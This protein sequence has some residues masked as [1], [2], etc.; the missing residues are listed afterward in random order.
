MGLF[1]DLTGLRFDRLAVLGRAPNSG[2]E[3]NWFVLCDCGKEKCVRSSNLKSG[4]VQSCG[5]FQR[6]GL[7]KRNTIPRQENPYII[8]GVP[9]RKLYQA[10]KDMNKR[11]H[12]VTKNENDRWYRE[13]GITVCQRWRDSFHLFYKDMAPSW[14]AG[15]TLER[16]NNDLGYSPENC[17]WATMLEQS[18]NQVKNVFL[19]HEG[20]RMT[21]A[22]WARE[23]GINYHRLYARLRKG[24]SI[25]DLMRA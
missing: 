13:R 22:Q 17:R 1:N 18:N 25:D 6:E 24:K 14:V 7:V 5:C 8:I 11:C 19:E 3:T 20:R 15:L 21:I 12:G 4:R 16:S 2:R 23:K 9:S 10:W